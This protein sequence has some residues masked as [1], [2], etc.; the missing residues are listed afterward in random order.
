MIKLQSTSERR[1]DSIMITS[2]SNL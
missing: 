2:L 1:S